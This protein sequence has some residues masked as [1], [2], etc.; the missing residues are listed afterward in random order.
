MESFIGW[1]S[2]LFV[3]GILAF[4]RYFR[5]H[6]SD[7]QTQ[8]D[9]VMEKEDK[10]YD[11]ENPDTLGLM[12]KTLCNLGCQPTKNPDD[13]IYVKYQGDNFHIEV[14]GMYARVWDP[15]WAEVKA[16]DPELPKIK[17]AVNKANFNFGPTVVFTIR[18]KKK[19][20]I[21]WEFT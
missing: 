11:I 5:S 14:G 4:S 19:S 9:E 17:E 7:P 13:T 10:Q 12:Y 15:F 6:D 20:L 3:I 1:G 21:S 16:D 2:F 18:M 8:N